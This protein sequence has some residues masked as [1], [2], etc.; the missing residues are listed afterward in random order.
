MEKRGG[1]GY[2]S[3]GM[4]SAPPGSCAIE[5]PACPRKL[6]PLADNDLPNNPPGDS[7]GENEDDEHLRDNSDDEDSNESGSGS[8][9]VPT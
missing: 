2:M 7:G 3:G 6:P 8:A 9:I 5:C 1:I 4:G